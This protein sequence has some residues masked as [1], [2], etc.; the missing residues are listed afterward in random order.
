MDVVILVSSS[1]SDEMF[2]GLAAALV[3]ADAEWGCF[4]TNDG[5]ALAADRDVHRLLSASAWSHVCEHS[6]ELYGDGDCGVSF[7]SQTQFSMIMGK[8]TRVVSL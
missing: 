8:A 4:F 1:Q 5:L 2:K 7:G 6:W 3:R